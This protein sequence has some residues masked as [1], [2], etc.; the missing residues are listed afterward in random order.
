MTSPVSTGAPY[1]QTIRW[2][3]SWR[4]VRRRTR[5]IGAFQDGQSALMLVADPLRHIVSIKK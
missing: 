4:E 5:V 3:A 2:S 1:G